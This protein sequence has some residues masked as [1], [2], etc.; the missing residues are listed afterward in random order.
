[1]IDLRVILHTIEAS[2]LIADG[3]IRAGIGMGHQLEALGHLCH[4]VAMAHPRNALFG[5]ALEELAGGIIIGLGF[6]VLPGSILL[7]RSD[8]TTQGMGHQ[9]AAIADTK[10]W[11]AHAEDLRVI[12]GGFL[13]IH[14][15]RA[16]GEDDTDGV[17]GLNFFQGGSIGL[18]LAVDIAFPDTACNQ[19][20]ILPAKVQNNDHL[21]IHT[22]ISPFG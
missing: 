10:D 14:T 12:V 22:V 9:L 21:M 5:Q 7:R 1:M 19:L 18:D 16:T 4:I 15:A 6:A 20:I 3:N 13:L 2:C 8:L 11:N 17:H